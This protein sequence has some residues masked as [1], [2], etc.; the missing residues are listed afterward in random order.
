M[1]E[2]Y[3]P[4]V[5]CDLGKHY[6]PSHSTANS[7]GCMND[8][9]MGEKFVSLSAAIRQPF[10]QAYYDPNYKQPYVAGVN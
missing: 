9:D 7:R 1:M 8:A 10:S 2:T 3:T 4:S 6:H 5:D